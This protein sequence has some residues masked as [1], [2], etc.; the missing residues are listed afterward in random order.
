MEAGARAALNYAD[1]D[2]DGDIEIVA[3]SRD[4]KIYVWHHDGTLVPGW[5]F[6]TGSYVEASPAVADLDGD[7]TC[8]VVASSNDG[9]LYV[10]TAGGVLLPGWPKY[11]DRA[12]PH[13]GGSH[14]QCSPV[15]FDVDRDGSLDIVYNGSLSNRTYVFDRFGRELRGWPQGYAAEEWTTT[16][17]I[18]ADLDG[19]GSPE[20]VT[21]VAYTSTTPNQNKLHAW[22]ADGTPVDGWPVILETYWFSPF[23]SIA[24]ADVDGNGKADVVATDPLHVYVLDGTGSMHSGWPV[25][26]DYDLGGHYVALGDLDDDGKVEVV[27]GST[28]SGKLHVLDDDGRVR[29]TMPIASIGPPALADVDGD[30]GIDIIAGLEYPINSVVVV[31]Q[32]GAVAEDLR[33]PTQ[34]YVHGVPIV[35]DLDADGSVEIGAADYGP[36]ANRLHAFAWDLQSQFDIR[37]APWPVYQH[38]A[39]HTGWLSPFSSLSPS[40]PESGID[41]V[42]ASPRPNPFR[43]RVT[44]DFDV[45]RAARARL[46]I[47]DLGGRRVKTVEDGV[48]TPGHYS[49]SWDGSDAAGVRAHGGVYFVRLWSARVVLSQK[50]L[51]ID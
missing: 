31:R 42:L 17:A 29:F 36:N 21:G 35:L 32:N 22:H 45:P 43:G 49:R 39:A 19:D 16:P 46:E 23:W 34:G 26:L 15:L 20:I 10:L 1:I 48:L 18:V 3:G 5:P 9:N 30:G 51:L 13:T 11:L 25:Q 2:G 47:Y 40:S 8:E 50:V 44:F 6:Q 4:G 7:G 28:L 24:A 12:Y 27:V 38:D 41:W 33:M 37:K 14:A